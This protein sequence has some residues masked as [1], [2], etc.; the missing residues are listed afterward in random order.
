MADNFGT[1]GMGVLGG[2]GA[3]AAL[4]SAIFP[5]VGTAIGAGLGAV[6][7]GI[8]AGRKISA[9][10]EALERLEDIPAF[11]PMQLD[12]LDR[13]KREKRAVESGFT[14]DFQVATDLNKEVLAGGQSVARD[15][16]A[17]NP[18]LAMA[19]MEKSSQQF[20]TGINKALGTISTRGLGLTH[21]IGELINS[22]SQRKLDIEV[23]KTTQQLGLATDVLQTSNVNAAQ[24]GARLPQHVGDI[25][26]GSGQIGEQLSNW[27]AAL[28]NKTSVPF[29]VPVGN[30]PTPAL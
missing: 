3:G 11:D 22:I 8:S 2:A 9:R 29:T 4:G 20:G 1:V 19:I 30:I 6:I 28:R 14:T 21:S 5:G 18:A 7:G 25:G 15:V 24:F 16:A 26:E 23:L 27:I 12:F 13:L 10:D 17:T